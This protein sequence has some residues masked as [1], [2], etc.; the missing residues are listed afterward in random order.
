MF[1][2]TYSLTP[3]HLPKE[4]RQYRNPYLHDPARKRACWG[5][6]AS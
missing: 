5:G 1:R 3:A 2:T 6:E 4:I